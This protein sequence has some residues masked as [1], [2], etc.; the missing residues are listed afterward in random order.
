M[1]RFW[2]TPR[3]YRRAMAGYGISG[4]FHL[5]D[6]CVAVD[7]VGHGTPKVLVGGVTREELTYSTY[8]WIDIGNLILGY[9]CFTCCSREETEGDR[10]AIRASQ[11]PGP[12]QDPA[13]PTWRGV[14][15]A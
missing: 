8:R 14:R 15:H 13:W 12:E 4:G 11:E 10:K 1:A 3:N 9:V 2:V 6:D 5:Y 7:K